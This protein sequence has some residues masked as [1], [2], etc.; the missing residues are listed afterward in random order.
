MNSLSALLFFVVISTLMCVTL[1]GSYVRF[2]NTQPTFGDADASGSLSSNSVSQTVAFTDVSPA[3]ATPYVAINNGRWSFTTNYSRKASAVGSG[4]VKDDTYYTVYSRQAAGKTLDNEL[5]EDGPT[6]LVP[7]F[8]SAS[9]VV[10]GDYA[11]IRTVNLAAFNFPANVYYT[12]SV[13][14]GTTQLFANAPYN[15]PTEWVD[16]AAGLYNFEWE[17]ANSKRSI[18]QNWSV[19]VIREKRYTIWLLGNGPVVTQDAI[20]NNRRSVSEVRQRRVAQRESV[21]QQKAAE[22]QNM[23]KSN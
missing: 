15:D 9:D 13:T 8:A 22:E 10:I 6:N 4:R 20:I 12:S 21:L 14:T 23:E 3:S 1:A 19:I 16:I 11:K 2:M 7:E 18:E 5:L 17:V